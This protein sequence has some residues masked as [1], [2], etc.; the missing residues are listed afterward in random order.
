MTLRRFFSFERRCGRVG[1]LRLPSLQAS[2][3]ASLF[4]SSAILL[5][6]GGVVGVWCTRLGGKINNLITGSVLTRPRL[7]IV[8][9]AR[10]SN[11]RWNNYCKA[12]RPSGCLFVNL[13]IFI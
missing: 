8:S 5:L 10:N 3:I 9:K 2:W 11:D 4:S 6:P 7:L 1:A 13:N 12:T